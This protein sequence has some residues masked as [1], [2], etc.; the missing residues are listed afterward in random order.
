[1]A[2]IRISGDTSGYVELAAPAVAGSTSL[3]VGVGYQYV[4][5]I[6]FTSSGTFAKGDYPWLRAIRVK[7]VGG[8]GGGGGAATTGANQN[9]IGGSGGGGQYSERFIL[10]SDLDAS[11]TVTV[12]A[13]GTG[14]AA[15]ANNGTAG[16]DSQFGLTKSY[17]T[18]AQGGGL[19]SGHAATGVGSFGALGGGGGTTGIGEFTIPGSASTPSRAWLGSSAITVN[20]QGGG[21]IWSAPARA[22]LSATGTDGS[23]GTGPGAGGS[24]GH[25]TQNQATARAGANGTNGQIIVELYA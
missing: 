20:Q 10:A 21:S 23:Q 3:T 19:G 12:G 2:K 24:G 4:Q 9:A 5:T 14:G 6:Y 22:Q 18:T 16:G 7:L 15:G 13:G 25:N 11:V 17:E 8:G 1:M